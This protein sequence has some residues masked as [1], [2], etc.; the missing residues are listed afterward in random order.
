LGC[1]TCIEEFIDI[2]KGWIQVERNFCDGKPYSVAVDN[3]RKTNKENY[4][5]VLEMCRAHAQLGSTSKILI[6]V[7][8]AI[9]DALRVDTV[10]ATSRRISIVSGATSL[11]DA[12]PYLV[13]IGSMDGNETYASV[14]LKARKLLLQE[15]SPSMEH[16]K[17]RIARAVKQLSDSAATRS[18]STSKEVT[19]FI[20]EN[21]PISDVFYSLLKSSYGDVQKMTLAELYLRKLYRAHTLKEFIRNHEHKVLRFT[22]T[23]KPIERPTTPGVNVSSVS[24][25]IK[26]PSLLNV[27]DELPPLISRVVVCKMVGSIKEIDSAE[28]F[29]KLLHFFPQSKKVIKTQDD[30]IN[31]LYIIVTD[32]TISPS[33]N[34]M[35]AL[36]EKLHSTLSAMDNKLEQAGIRRVS[37]ILNYDA[38]EPYADFPLPAILTFKSRF[39]FKEDALFRNIEPS[40]AYL[41]DLTR[42]EKNFDVRRLASC[43]TTTGNVHLFQALPRKDAVEAQ[44]SLKK[45]P[46]IFVRALSF[47]L[48]FSTSNVEKMLVSALNVLDVFIHEKKSATDNHLFMNF[49]GDYE[50]AVLDPAIV[51]QSI[52][53]IMKDHWDKVSALGVTEVETKLVFRPT[54]NSSPVAYRIVVSNPT[55][56]VHEMNTFV[57]A[58][59]ESSSTPIFKLVGK[60]KTSLGCGQ[61]VAWPYPLEKPFDKYR[62]AALRSSDSLYCYDLPALFEAAVEE[63]WNGANKGDNTQ[64][65][66]VNVTELVVQKKDDSTDAWTMN[67]YHSN[68]LKL[69]LVKRE[70]GLNNVGMVAWLMTLR[71]VEYPDGRQVILIA[72]DITYKAGSFGTKEDVVFKLASE[73]AREH[74]I[75]RLF[76]AA[77]SGARIGLAEGVKK[78]FQV[79]FKDSSKPENGFDFLYV[80]KEDYESLNEEKQQLIVEETTYNGS[81]V[82]AIK[83]IIGSEPDLGVENLK[84]SGLIAGETSTAYNE[85]FTMTIVLGRTVGIGAYLVRLGQRT[86]QKSSSSPIILT[87]YQ[88]LNKLMGVDVYLTNDQLGGPEIMYSNGVSHLTAK[89]HLSSVTAAIKWLSF[90]P[91][92]RGKPLPISNMSGIDIID[93]QIDFTPLRG[94]P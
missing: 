81:Q 23:S 77:N 44:R 40:N 82:Y 11:G 9:A 4:N 67:D 72:N 65:T 71:T 94:V 13:D 70:A 7:I 38:S 91:C 60:N 6:G 76:V 85:I 58:V 27:S 12:V 56:Y 88:A 74:C 35:N 68:T 69:T 15:S 50:M 1:R 90:V 86:I 79:G 64:T 43:P 57:E 47:I 21:V 31:V 45:S 92:S 14:S 61:N 46:R 48:E 59:H 41:L 33:P 52:L 3:L 19:N 53:P 66:F 2:L 34:A 62:K 80:S 84:G 42:L 24:S 73:Y 93:R 39:Q 32:Q 87:G 10:S 28:S 55:G 51:Q 63:Q 30:S 18:N 22:F 78:K 37:F 20:N 16:R 26:S 89:D 29:E 49:I 36:S 54:T 17:I 75:P 25:I 5:Y 8:D 83:D